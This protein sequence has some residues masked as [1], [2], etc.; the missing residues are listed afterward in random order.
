MSSPLA[1]S[2]ASVE[3]RVTGFDPNVEYSADP[4]APNQTPNLQSTLTLFVVSSAKLKRG[5]ARGRR[6]TDSSANQL[7]S[8]LEPNYAIHFKVGESI[9]V[10]SS[11]PTQ[12]T[13]LF[14]LF[15]M[16]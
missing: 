11:G 7:P 4:D 8:P 10:Y 12:A 5:K 14:S 3:I 9:V 15:Y 6:K 16:L 13:T 2:Y 1:S